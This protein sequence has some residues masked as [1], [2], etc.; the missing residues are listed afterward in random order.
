VNRQSMRGFLA[1]VEREY[2]D[3]IVRIREPVRRE[4]D[5][6]STVFEL[7]RAGRSPIVVF[8]KVEGFDMPVVTNLAGNR[9]LIAAA[10]GVEPGALA[11]TF[12]ERCQNYRHVELVDCAPWQELVIEGD[13]VDLTKLPIPVHF[14][15]DAAPYI[16]AGQICARDP[17]T[18][19]DTT[20]FHRLMLKGRN[21]LGV[22]LHSRRRMYEFHR[23]AEVRGEPLPAAVTLGIHPIHY[24]GSMAYHYPPNIR[25]YE[26]IGAL[27]DEPYRVARCG[28][29]ELEVPEGAEIVI[30]GKILN[31]VREPE[32][33]FSEFTGYAS[34]RS[35]EN[36]FVAERIQM[37]R[38]AMF[39]S[40][41]SGTASDHILISSVARESYARDWVTR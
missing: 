33:P 31:D 39:H 25:K 22:S 11:T 8:E 32:G 27:F 18:G 40:I 9:R 35:T 38:N 6:T 15:G 12:R 13:G 34:Y 26:I 36:V 5:I 30:E 3:E 10:M 24:M 37:R 20:G 2:P 41:A 23:R 19:V 17:Q 14:A 16:T 4:L 1:M 7:E 21:R 29:A 28:T